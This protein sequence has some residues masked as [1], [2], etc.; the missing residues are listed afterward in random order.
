MLGILVFMGYRA[1]Q[2]MLA[3]PRTRTHCLGLPSPPRDLIRVCGKPELLQLLE[4]PRFWPKPLNS[5]NTVRPALKLAATQWEEHATR[6]QALHACQFLNK[7]E[8]PSDS[9][10]V[11]PIAPRFSLEASLQTVLNRDW[12][13]NLSCTTKDNPSLAGGAWKRGRS[14][15]ESG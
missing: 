6:F 11:A 10:E 2:D 13:T 12:N 4:T 7:A 3:Q 15:T 5:K 8:G 9:T 14:R 1:G